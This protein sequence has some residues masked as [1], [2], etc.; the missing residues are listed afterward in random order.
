MFQ[1]LTQINKILTEMLDTLTKKN[2][3]YVGNFD[4]M[5]RDFGWKIGDFD[6]NGE[7][8]KML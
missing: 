2:E 3:I 7:Q 6:P 1:I 5:V 8:T 4:G